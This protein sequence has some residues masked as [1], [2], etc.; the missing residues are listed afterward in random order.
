MK[1]RDRMRLVQALDQREAELRD[2]WAHL[3]KTARG[4]RIL[5]R[6]SDTIDDI[7]ADETRSGESRLIALLADCALIR[8]MIRRRDSKDER[9]DNSGGDSGSAR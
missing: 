1:R 7:I 9:A 5:Q 8:H 4:S 3:E 6:A 2:Y